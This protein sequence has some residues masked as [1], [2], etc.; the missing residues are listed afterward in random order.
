M[1]TVSIIKTGTLTTTLHKP[2]GEAHLYV[3]FGYVPLKHF[4]HTRGQVSGT[5]NSDP[6]NMIHTS[7]QSTKE[8]CIKELGVDLR[9][10]TL[11][12][13]RKVLYE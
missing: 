12:I 5:M 4:N 6:I 1:E 13:Q 3:Q 9:S 8:G 2:A 7:Q 10:S 11:S